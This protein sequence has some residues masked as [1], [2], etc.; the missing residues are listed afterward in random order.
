MK[1]RALKGSKVKDERG[2]TFTSTRYLSYTGFASILF[3]PYT[4][5]NYAVVKIRLKTHVHKNSF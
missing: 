5:N 2:S 1:G 3:T 4:R